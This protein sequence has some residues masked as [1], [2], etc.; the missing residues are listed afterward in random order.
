MKRRWKLE[1]HRL[2]RNGQFD[3][4]GP[5]GNSMGMHKLSL[6]TV[7]SSQIFVRSQNEKSI[8]DKTKERKNW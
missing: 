6:E 8:F 4:L 5:A 1:L 7:Q 3:L 2:I